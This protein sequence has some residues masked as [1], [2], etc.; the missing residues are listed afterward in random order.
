MGYDQHYAQSVVEHFEEE[1]IPV[2]LIRTPTPISPLYVE[3]RKW[4]ENDRIDLSGDADYKP[5]DRLKAELERVSY[6]FGSSGTLLID[7]PTMPDGSH[8]DLVS[9]LIAGFAAF[10]RGLTGRVFGEGKRKL[11]PLAA[12]RYGNNS[13]RTFVWNSRDAESED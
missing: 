2:E 3:L 8:C 11:A 9:A 6:H 10:S 12:S 13:P 4:L 1:K 7:L 5:S